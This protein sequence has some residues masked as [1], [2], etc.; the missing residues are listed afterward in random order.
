MYLLVGEEGGEG[1]LEEGGEGGLEKGGGGR[2][3][4]IE[5]ILHGYS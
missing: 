5:C 3:R 1:G 4:G 2:E